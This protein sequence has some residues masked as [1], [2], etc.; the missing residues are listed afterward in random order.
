MNSITVLYDGSCAFCR[1]CV[2]WLQNQPH[3]LEMIF[4]PSQ[5]E[6]ARYLYPGLER[7]HTTN[8]LTVVDDG[9]GVYYGERAYLMCLYALQEYREMSLRLSAPEIA[10]F[11]KRAF[12]VVTSSR[13]TL[14]QLFITDR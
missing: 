8:E 5:S 13:H 4:I 12:G 6:E 14:S 7:E 1:H 2:A 3:Y 11:V 10:P 9:G